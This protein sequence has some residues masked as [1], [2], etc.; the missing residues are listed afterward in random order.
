MATSRRTPTTVEPAICDPIPI[1]ASGSRE[2]PGGRPPAIVFAH[3]GRKESSSLA[4]SYCV[5][6]RNEVNGELVKSFT[7]SGAEMVRFARGAA[8]LGTW[9]A[10][11]MHERVEKCLKP[12]P[13]T[14]PG[15][16]LRRSG[17]KWMIR[18]TLWD[19]WVYRSNSIDRVRCIFLRYSPQLDSGPIDSHPATD[20]VTRFLAPALRHGRHTPQCEDAFFVPTRLSR[21]VIGLFPGLDRPPYNGSG[22]AKPGSPPRGVPRPFALRDGSRN[23]PNRARMPDQ[24]PSRN[25]RRRRRGVAER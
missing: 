22:S 16:R 6:A 14:F 8:P 5:A 9:G 18:G 7:S 25:R 20:R 21:P 19:D 11:V 13:N 12:L 1:R 15:A 23:R 24:R 10:A 3:G 4:K 2:P 17:S